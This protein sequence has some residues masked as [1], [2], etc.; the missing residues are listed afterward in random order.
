MP[1]KSSFDANS[2]LI[3]GA[4]V[5]LPEHVVQADVRIRTGRIEA[6]ASSIPPEPDDQVIEGTGQYLLPGFI[7]IHNHGAQGFD[8]SL[9][10]YRAE[11][12]T[13]DLSA[14]AFREGLAKALAFY[15]QQ[16]VTRVLPTSLAAPVADL[17]FAF[18]QLAAFADDAREPL[19]HMLAC[20]EPWYCTG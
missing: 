19:R 16:G 1:M 12:N 6:I 8:A 7:D 5:V 18:G 4:R 14:D 9:G 11:T 15:Q 17:L 3:R 13:F 20:P 2:T 10:N